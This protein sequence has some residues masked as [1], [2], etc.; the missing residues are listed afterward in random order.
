MS[1]RALAYF[2]EK[3]ETIDRRTQGS[4]A[5]E[6]YVD[7]LG[8]LGRGEE[9]IAA[10]LKLLPPGSHTMGIAPSILEL[11]QQA[12]NYQAMLDSSRAQGDVLAYAT[13]LLF[14]RGEG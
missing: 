13:A 8:K 6:T 14:S 9:A 4:A 3:A 5:A 12:G 10:R 2:R 11:S 1:S 7:L